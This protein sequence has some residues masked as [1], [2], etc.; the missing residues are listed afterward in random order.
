MLKRKIIEQLHIWREKKGHKSLIIIGARQVGKTFAVREFGKT[1]QSFIE[2]NFLQTPELL[3]IFEGSL[4]VDSIKIIIQTVIPTAK[5]IDG[6]TL[7]LLD[8]IQECGRAIQSLK[9][10]TEDGRYDVI[11]TGSALGMSFKQSISY[12]VGYVEY[13]DM[14]ALDFEEFMWAKGISSDTIHLLSEYYQKLVKIPTAIHNR[15]LAVL[16]EYMVIGGMPEVVE[17]YISTSNLLQADTVQRRIRRDYIYDIA[18]Y[19]PA[20]IRLKAQKCFESIQVQLT[21]ENHKFQ[22]STV[23]SKAT[24]TKF[25]TSID[26]LVSAFITRPVYHLKRIEYPLKAFMEENNF[27]LYMT[28]IGMLM[29]GFDYSLKVAIL[30]DSDL[31]SK[32]SNLLLGL[33]KG[34]LYESLVADMLFKKNREDIFFYKDAKSSSEIEFVIEGID[35]AVP[36]EVK[37]GRSKANSLHNILLD[38]KIEKGYKISLQ[39]IGCAGKRVTLPIYMLMFI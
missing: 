27:R 38:E 30:S 26:W 11:A 15:I 39:N 10:W 7:L 4:D 14:C 16:K 32:S 35:G 20:N 18:H 34:G 12:P 21:K 9:F 29:A 19:A 6:N 1:Y 28:D 2:L 24:A 3:D 17:T 31:E 22:Y 25:E 33:A 13:R 8:E 23:E 37:A 36:I 5:F